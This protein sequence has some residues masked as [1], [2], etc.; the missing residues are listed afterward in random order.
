[1]SLALRTAYNPVGP[2][3]P[4]YWTPLQLEQSLI[5]PD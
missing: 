1:M 5:W 2:Q 3:A 4:P